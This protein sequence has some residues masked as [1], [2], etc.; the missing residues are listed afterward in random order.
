[1]TIL[2]PT[3]SCY[4]HGTGRRSPWLLSAD[5]TSEV[6]ARINKLAQKRPTLRAILAHF[7][8]LARLRFALLKLSMGLHLRLLS[9]RFYYGIQY[10]SLRREAPF[11][12]EK[13]EP[14]L[15]VI[16]LDSRPDRW[17]E[18][19]AHLQ[20]LGMA[21][22]REPAVQHELG[23]AG[24]AWSHAALLKRYETL[25]CPFLFV[26]EDDVHF[27]VSHNEIATLISEFIRRPEIDVLCLAHVTTG[28]RVPISEKFVVATKIRT[29]ACYVA[30]SKAFPHLIKV[31][32]ESANSISSG[33]NP[34]DDALDIR[35]Q[36][37]QNGK[38]LFAIPTNTIAS[39]RPS[40][41]DIQQGFVNYSREYKVDFG[42]SG[43]NV[44]NPA[45]NEVADAPLD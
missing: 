38:L 20:E 41:S 6:R 9:R 14:T 4:N 45:F 34:R 31:F 35:W 3:E 28:I 43:E 7:R 29:T 15:E 2:R 21:Y 27:H 1:M 26:A 30:K 23:L 36:E 5:P 40:Y 12:L 32:E 44:A 17:A 33:G 25:G 18:S 11:P 19:S 13:S 24:C 16:N 22:C 42:V 8:S 39:Q 37:L 10:L